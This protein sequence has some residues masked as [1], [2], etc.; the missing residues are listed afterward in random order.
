MAKLTTRGRKRLKT[1][2]FAGP[3]RTFPI[4]NKGHAQ[5]AIRDVGIAEHHGSIS[6][7]EGNRIKAKAERKL[8]G[9]GLLNPGGK[10]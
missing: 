8:H 4:E 10:R 1:S 6:V 2:Q 9:G 3:G 7:A 5:A